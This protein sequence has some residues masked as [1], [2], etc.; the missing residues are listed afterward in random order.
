[1]FNIYFADA[2]IRT[3]DLWCLEQPLYQLSHN[4]TFFVLAKF[5]LTENNYSVNMIYEINLGN[6]WRVQLGLV[7]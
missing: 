4:Q 1:M 3:A 7:R 6:V 2:W 5:M